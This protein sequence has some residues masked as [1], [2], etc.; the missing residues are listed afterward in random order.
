MFFF[1]CFLTFGLHRFFFYYYITIC[2]NSLQ[3]PE[4]FC[5]S[6]NAIRA[7]IETVVSRK[8]SGEV[9]VWVNYPFKCVTIAAHAPSNFPLA[10]GFFS[11][12][13][14]VDS[15]GTKTESFFMFENQEELQ[16][17]AETLIVSL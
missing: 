8:F 17:A 7:S 13:L 4:Q 16:E 2:W 5:G 11:V 6:E 12:Q 3:T 10:A 1:C 14:Q 15:W 9:L